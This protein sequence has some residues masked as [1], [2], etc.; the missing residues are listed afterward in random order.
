MGKCYRCGT[1]ISSTASFCT[2]CGAK[3]EGRCPN[4]GAA[5]NEGAKFCVV[6]GTQIQQPLIAVQTD[7]SSANTEKDR[8]A[9][10][11]RTDIA[12][13]KGDL[14]SAVIEDSCKKNKSEI[15][16]DEGEEINTGLCNEENIHTSASSS[17][18]IIPL[19][20]TKKKY[21][22]A[23]FLIVFALIGGIIAYRQI[24]SENHNDLTHQKESENNTIFSA[25]DLKDYENPEQAYKEAEQAMIDYDSMNWDI[26]NEHDDEDFD[27]L[28][29]KAREG[30]KFAAYK[31]NSKLAKSDY[32]QFLLYECNDHYSESAADEAI[33]FIK[34]LAAD[35]D[36]KFE[37]ILADAYLLNA[38]KGPEAEKEL[39]M[40][41]YSIWHAKAAEHGH[42]SALRDRA[43]LLQKA[44]NMTKALEFYEKAAESVDAYD[45]KYNNYTGLE[46]NLHFLSGNKGFSLS[47]LCQAEI[48]FIYEFG[49]LGKKDLKKALYWYEKTDSGYTQVPNDSLLECDGPFQA[50]EAIERV[51]E[52]MKH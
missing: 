27:K 45:S 28:W 49:I 40:Q 33:K 48:G 31:G 9:P 16:K 3:L 18:G 20:K 1:S 22:A 42:P 24:I 4:C 37:Y 25:S 46:T 44:G 26:E 23:I 15:T 38:K 34:I 39:N 52:K 13:P 32:A 12:E 47:V 7:V 8:N 30:Y 35:G 21:I 19:Q 41:N 17:G 43:I 6:C 11:Q 10:I 29:Q 50:E 14:C 36:A 5:F 51:K 2:N